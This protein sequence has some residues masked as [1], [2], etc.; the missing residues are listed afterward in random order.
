MGLL[1]AL[2]VGTWSCVVCLAPFA[3][4]RAAVLVRF[5]EAGPGPGQTVLVVD[6]GGSSTA[7]SDLALSPGHGRSR[8]FGLDAIQLD[9]LGSRLRAADFPRL[10]TRY[11]LPNPGG[12]FTVT[13]TGARS[14]T[15]YAGAS[16]PT[17]LRLLNVYLEQILGTR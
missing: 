11:G 2:V 5:V 16:V 17:G 14:A 13:T 1:V 6:V 7:T 15:V 12:V 4:T 8:R 3:S 10:R 9:M